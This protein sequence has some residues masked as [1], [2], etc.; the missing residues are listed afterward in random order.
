MIHLAE[1][2]GL[3]Q[4]EEKAKH[5]SVVPLNDRKPESSGT[6]C[7]DGSEATADD[8]EEPLQTQQ[9]SQ[10]DVIKQRQEEECKGMER[11][12]FAQRF[13]FI[14]KTQREQQ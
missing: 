1:M 8:A 9:L 7:P 14:G 10:E 13:R 4:S 5:A 12:H 6:N 11:Q 3:Q 2:D